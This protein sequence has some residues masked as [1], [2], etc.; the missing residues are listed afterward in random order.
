[1]MITRGI[2]VEDRYWI[3]DNRCWKDVDPFYNKRINTLIPV[4]FNS[5]EH[6]D[7]MT[8]ESVEYTT[9]GTAEKAWKREEDGFYLYKTKRWEY[10]VLVSGILDALNVSHVHYS[11]KILYNKDCCRCRNMATPALSRIP[12]KE[13][14][15]NCKDFIRYVIDHF[16]EDFETMCIVD[17]LICNQDRH[18][19]NWG[20]YMDNKTGRLVSLHPL[21]DHNWEFGEIAMRND[22]PSKVFEGYSL[23]EVAQTISR[24]RH[25]TLDGSKLPEF[26]SELQ[27]EYFIKACE[28]CY[29]K[30]NNRSVDME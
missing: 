29:I 4:V 12:A 9:G 21:F 15:D 19:E 2:S 26:H 23:R 1:M 3:N 14:R 25:L 16:R 13:V 22:F 5:P 28:T 24:T 8:F 11:H 7:E 17:Y 10:E 20:F 27:K 30:I 18:G 6:L